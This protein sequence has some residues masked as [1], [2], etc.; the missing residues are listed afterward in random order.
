MKLLGKKEH[1]TIKNLKMAILI[2]SSTRTPENDK[3]GNWMAKEIKR[4]G[5]TLVSRRIIP[6][7]FLAIGGAVLDAVRMDQADAV[8]VSGGTGLTRMDVTIEA[9]RPL[10][11][12]E[13]T[14]FGPLFARLSFEEIGAAAMLSRA[15]AGSIGES[16]V[17]CIPGSLKAC[18]L[19]CRE[20]IF[21][22]VGH[23]VAHLRN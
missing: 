21:M 2:V 22:E 11:H 18:K 10:F 19:A 1:Q 12:K 20:L 15:S 8:I 23:L 7:D 6:D 17:F 4:E 3:S 14:A 5:H 13:L 9:C 16:A